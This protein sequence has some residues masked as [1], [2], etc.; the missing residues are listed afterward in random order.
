MDKKR[1]ALGFSVALV[2]VGIGL[3]RGCYSEPRA[4]TATAKARDSAASPGERP[5]RPTG[6]A[7]P[8]TIVLDAGLDAANA[9]KGPDVFFSAP[10]GGSSIEQLGHSRPSEANPEAPMSVT[11]DSQG[12][13]FVLDQVNGRILR[14][15]ANGKPEGVIPLKQ[16]EAAQDL[17]IAQDGSVAVLDRFSSKSIVMYDQQGK[18]LGEIPLQGEGLEET[19]LA[20]GV[21][22]DGNDVYVEKEHGPLVRVGTTDGKPATDRGEIPGRPSRDGTIFV[23][24]G[25]IDV[26][27]GR[28]YVSAIDRATM[29]HRF[30]RELRQGAEIRGILMLDTDKQGTIYLATYLD[31]GG[32]E[33]VVLTCL[34][35]LKG[36]P[37]GSVPL[38]VNTLPEE[39]FRDFAVLD[40]GGV[41]YS[42]RTEQGVAYQRY[43]CQ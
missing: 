10:W 35:P 7:G 3:A 28:M 31:Q 43:D 32:S 19:G 27:L 13:M 15:G 25:V 33:V 29:Q 41:I 21:F 9:G 1:F 11:M 18:A 38:P 26:A 20:T 12:R 16:Q 24:A 40:E 34:E 2:A 42:V 36:F 23:N 8:V 14:V 17:A 6:P 30:T 37:M 22:V 39:T 5:A 4:T